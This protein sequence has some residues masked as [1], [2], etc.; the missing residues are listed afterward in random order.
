MTVRTDAK[1]KA[2]FTKICEEMGM[3]ANSAINALIQTVVVSK[4][5]S[6]A[7]ERR[8]G[9]DLALEDVKRGR[10]HHADNVDEMFQQIFGNDYVLD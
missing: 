3:S 4:G 2:E 6:F 8:S 10:V 7:A 1:L 9:L 5:A